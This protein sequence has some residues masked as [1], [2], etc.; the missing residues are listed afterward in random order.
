MT[1]SNKELQHIR[2]DNNTVGN[3][4]AKMLVLRMMNEVEG[5]G[6]LD[7][8]YK[9]HSKDFQD[10]WKVNRS[11][12][13]AGVEKFLAKFMAS[14]S[15][16]GAIIHSQ[17]QQTANPPEGQTFMVSTHKTVFAYHTGP[18]L[19]I[20]A[21][22]NR[23]AV[24]LKDTFAIRQG[25]GWHS[26]RLWITEHWCAKNDVLETVIKQVAPPALKPVYMGLGWMLRPR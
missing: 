22:R 16:W 20:K 6:K 4:P 23:V 7:A 2:F 5:A 12:D 18:F 14:F 8:L 3:T 15:E 25:T 21:S 26:D 17:K 24:E 9:Y 11:G 10:H 13:L 1:F 19:G